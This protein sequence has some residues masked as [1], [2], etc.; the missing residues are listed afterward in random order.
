MPVYVTDVMQALRA[1]DWR[2]PG[3]GSK[4]SGEEAVRMPR[5]ERVNPRYASRVNRRLGDAGTKT[6]RTQRC[7]KI[8]SLA[9]YWVLRNTGG[10]TVERAKWQGHGAG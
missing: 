4:E 2:S 6:D 10:H 8:V 5:R 3:R 9:V 1:T 7:R